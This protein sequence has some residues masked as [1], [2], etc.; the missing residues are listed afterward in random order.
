MAELA[1]KK[2]NLSKV[3]AKDLSIPNTQKVDSAPQSGNSMMSAIM[4]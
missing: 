2:K 4:A 1:A 3:E